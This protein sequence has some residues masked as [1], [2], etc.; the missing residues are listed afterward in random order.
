M[1]D[2]NDGPLGSVLTH[3][4]GVIVHRRQ[5]S[6]TFSFDYRRFHNLPQGAISAYG[7]GGAAANRTKKVDLWIPL[8]VPPVNHFFGI[9]GIRAKYYLM[10]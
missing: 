10:I 8:I 3:A 9:K 5:D 4:V 2:I 6:R 1:W 7:H